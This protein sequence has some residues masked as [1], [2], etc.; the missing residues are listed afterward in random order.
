MIRL[1]RDHLTRIES[2]GTHAIV[3]LAALV[4]LALGASHAAAQTDEGSDPT[5]AETSSQDG[6]SDES[7]DEAPGVTLTQ[8]PF[9]YT[10]PIVDSL[11]SVGPAEFLG[12]DLPPDPE[13]AKAVR[14]KGTI[15]VQ[16]KGDIMVRL[17]REPEYQNWL[18]KRG[19]S[20]AAPYWTSKRLP[21]ITL[22][23][24][25]V[26]GTP[27]VLLIDNGY[28]VRTPKRVKAHLAIQYER[29][30]G[31]ATTASSTGSP[32]PPREDDFIVPRSNAEETVP[33]PPP[34]PAASEDETSG[35]E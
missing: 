11:F 24:P 18:K 25:L 10:A 30:G 20:K 17:F 34:P 35:D 32:S 4:L 26:P 7:S 31:P 13:N 27:V 5:D 2:H 16:G 9:E 22:D 3:T 14:L 29:T 15:Q 33:P 21:S 12:I 8:D 23:H 19:G 28:S 6:A 1:L